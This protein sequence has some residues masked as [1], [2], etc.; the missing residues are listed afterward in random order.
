MGSLEEVY[1]KIVIVTDRDD[2]Y[3]E[4]DILKELTQVIDGHNGKIL[5]T[6]VNNEWCK[7][8][9]INSIN[10]EFTIEFLLLVIPLSE[11]GAIETVLLD[12]IAQK[13]DYDKVIVNQSKMFVDNM[14]PEVRYMKRRRDKL[15]AWFNIYFSIRVPEDFYKERQRIFNNFPWEENAYINKV[16][17]KL[18]EL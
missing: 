11:N 17:C 18:S 10:E 8:C 5:D 7:V 4:S 1:R 6:L 15:K 13:D 12:S 3:S 9:F 16:F 14:D 2:D